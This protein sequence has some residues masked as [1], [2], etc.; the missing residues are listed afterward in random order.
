MREF[1]RKL[2][3]PRES[4]GPSVGPS[5]TSGSSQEGLETP[6]PE[7]RHVLNEEDDFSWLMPPGTVVDPMAW[8]KYWHDQITH[9]VAGFVDIFCDDGELVD[10]M[11]TS[12]FHT[13]LCVGNGLSLE[14]WAL[15]AAGFDVTALDL[16]P[17]ATEAVKGATPPEDHL[18]R[19]LGGRSLLPS[20]R[21]E[22][23]AGDLSDARVCPGP[24]DVV[25]ERR[26]LQ[27][28]PQQDRPAALQAV[29]NRLAPQG[30][31]FSHSHDGGWRPP[32]PRSHACEDWFAAQGWPRWQRDTPATGRVVWLFVSTG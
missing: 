32:A 14:P 6:V 9:G 27:L 2:I 3:R 26:T 24:F 28:Y 10:A 7:Q 8:D 11:R 4:G 12:Q 1:L 20:G 23:L 30:I 25:I 19:L 31:F 29:A 21:L 18:R 22:F 13:V 16:S 15:A 17:F 5:T